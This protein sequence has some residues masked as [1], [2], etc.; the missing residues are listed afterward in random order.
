MKTQQAFVKGICQLLD[1][2][3]YTDADIYILYTDQVYDEFYR[4][5]IHA[6]GFAFSFA[7]SIP[8]ASAVCVL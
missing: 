8:F 4:N 3:V 6:A 2:Y 7:F 5:F 1:I